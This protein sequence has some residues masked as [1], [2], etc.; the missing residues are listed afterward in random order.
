LEKLL[1]DCIADKEL[2]AAQQSEIDFIYKTTAEKYTINEGKLKRYA[3]RR[4]QLEKVV[5]LLTK[6]RQK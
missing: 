5:M 4:N 3:R 2:F 6:Y 1:V